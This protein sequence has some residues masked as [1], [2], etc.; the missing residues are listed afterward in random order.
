MNWLASQALPL[1]GVTP[2]VGLDDLEPLR[3]ILQD[4]RLV[5]VGE[6]THGTHEFY[7][8]RHRL[9]E[10]L[11]REMGF[12]ILALESPY[13]GS[14]KLN[15]YVLTGKGSAPEALRAM[16]A[17][18]EAREM[19]AVA[20]WVRVYNQSAPADRQVQILGFDV[21]APAVAAKVLATYLERVAP[22]LMAKAGE[23]IWDAGLMRQPAGIPWPQGKTEV[24]ASLREVEEYLAANRASLVDQTSLKEFR[25]AYDAARHLQQQ[26]G[27]Y[28]FPRNN[29]DWWTRESYMTQN[30]LSILEAEGPDARAVVWAHNL[31]VSTAPGK[32]GASLKEALNDGYY[33][34]GITFGAGRFRAIN[35]AT[36]P[37]AGSGGTPTEE[38]FEV[39]P[40]E[41]G[42]L[43][44]DLV[45]ARLDTSLIDLRHTPKTEA[46]RLWLER[47][48]NMRWIGLRFH[49][50]K[51]GTYSGQRRLTTLDG[52]IYIPRT[53]GYQPLD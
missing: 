8:M 9:L 25:L 32:I 43:E 3:T 16:H 52:L 24:L 2:G 23:R 34:L 19:V 14:L 40:A 1:K 12:R 49:P 17:A 6:A 42:F 5:G 22:D 41:P 26:Y 53:T 38:E 15:E 45:C 39:G 51:P 36:S 28:M 47:E 10:F 30:L 21:G 35:A 4:V 18:M 33:V 46:V 31:H 50:T 37:I 48:Q 27:L 13:F 7:T 20:E 44:F 29:A 11:V